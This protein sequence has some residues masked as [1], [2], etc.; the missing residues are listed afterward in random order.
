[1]RGRGIGSHT[2]QR[3]GDSVIWLTPPE[4]LNALGKFDLDPCAA[5]RPRPWLTATHHF[6]GENYDGLAEPWFGRVWLNPPYDERL[7]LWTK[8]MSEHG[9]GIALIFART[10]TEVW[11]R[12]IW[13]K[14]DS[15]L[16]VYGRIWFY[17]PDGTKGSINSGG[18]SALIAYSA[19]DTGCLRLSGIRGSL[20]KRA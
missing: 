13:P 17:K 9:S 5:P 3:K 14:A 10:E 7:A 20:Q 15:I 2:K 6:D 12:W 18:P 4:I 16:F 19:F 8:K 1:V 11:E